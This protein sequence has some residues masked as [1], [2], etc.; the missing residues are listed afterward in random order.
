MNKYNYGRVGAPPGLTVHWLNMELLGEFTKVYRL[1]YNRRF[2]HYR[3][4]R[5]RKKSVV[6]EFIIIRTS[7]RCYRVMYYNDDYK[8]FQYFSSRNYSDCAKRIKEIYRIFKRLEISAEN[9]K[10]NK[11]SSR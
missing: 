3:Y 6:D 7:K 8:Y 2:H 11:G 1:S 10:T 5:Y 9:K 4:V